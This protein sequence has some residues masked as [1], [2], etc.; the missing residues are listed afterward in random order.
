MRQA[1]SPIYRV[2]QFAARTGVTVRTLH[3]YNR[4]GLLKPSWRSGAGHRLYR[5]SDVARLEQIVVLK[6]LGLPLAQ[7]GR[8][9]E[10]RSSLAD[11]LGRQ[12]HVLAEKRDRLDAAIAAIQ[13]AEA[14]LQAGRDRDWDL[15]A[16]IVREIKMQE[17]E[18]WT[19]KYYSPDARA[20]VE[21]RKTLWN[22]DLQAQVTRDWNDLLRDVAAALDEDPA[23]PVAQALAARWRA[24]LAGFTGGDPAVQEGLNRLWADQANWPP[25]T[26]QRAHVDPAVQE[27]IVKAM[28]A[29]PQR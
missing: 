17:H 9:L 14:S 4:L 21:A 5:E 23:G 25:E 22:P 8:L 3:H 2:R 16:A 26:R 27:F 11:T 18:D 15:F 6:F 29:R 19:T 7:I 20:K 24:L 10:T 1:P 13:R 12:R 28:R